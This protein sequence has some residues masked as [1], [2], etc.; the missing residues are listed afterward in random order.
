M[1]DRTL[2]RVALAISCRTAVLLIGWSTT[3]LSAGW[4]QQMDLPRVEAMPNMPQPY[5]M[6]D[7][8]SVTLAYDSLVFDLRREGTYLPLVWINPNTINYPDSPSFG[9]HTVVGTPFPQSAEAINA[10]PALVGATLSGIGKTDQFGR[11]W[12]LMAREWF[13]RRPEEN[14]YLNHPVASSG[15]DW[16]YDTMPNVFFLQLYDLYPDTPGFGEQL[17]TVADRWLIALGAMGG[18]AAPW[19]I[20]SMNYRG[21]HLSTMSPNTSGVIEPEAAGALAWILYHAYHETGHFPYRQGAEWAMEF[22]EG[23]SSNPSYELQLPYGAYA[24][25][26]MNAEIGTDFDVEKLLNW[27]FDV[28]PLRNWGAILG[29]WGGYDVHGLIGEAGSD[30]YAFAMNTFEHVGALVPLVRYDDRFSRAIGKWALNAA[31]AARLFYTAHLP[32]SLQDSDAWSHEYDPKSTIA[33]EGLRR[34]KFGRTP[35]ATGDAIEGGW[36]A[37]N[38]ALYGSSH[39]GIFGA[40]IDTTDV[41]GILRLDVRATDYFQDDGFPTYLLYNP[42]ETQRDVTFE[43]PNGTFDLYD[44]AGNRFVAHA[45]TGAAQ[46]ALPADDALQIVLLPAGEPVSY[47]FGKMYVGESIADYRTD[48]GVPNMPPRVK[49]L[50][51]APER[52]G[53]S[54]EVAAYCTAEDEDEDAG[55][56]SYEWTTSAGSISGEGAVVTWTAPDAPHEEVRLE[57]AVHDTAGLKA[58]EHITFDV[59]LQPPVI[60][61]VTANPRKVDLG[62]TTTLVCEAD[63]P[64]SDELSFSWTADAGDIEPSGSTATWSVPT[65]PGEFTATCTVRS[66]QGTSARDSIQVMVRDLSAGGTGDLVAHFRLDGDASDASAYGHDATLS[67]AVPVQDHRGNANSALRFD[68]RDDYVRVPNSDILNFRE[69]I[70]VAFWIQPDEFLDREAYP[71]SHGNWERRWKI[72][73][74]DQRLRW[75]I[76]TA[77][78]VMDLDSETLL[79]VGTFYHVVARYDGTD[80]EIYLD[81]RLDAFDG[82]AGDLLATDVDLMLGQVLPDNNAYNFA[83]VLDDVRIYEYA[84]STYDVLDLH[85]EATPSRADF[86]PASFA[87]HPPYPN[88]FDRATTIRFDLPFTAHVSLRIHDILG[89]QVALLIDDVLHA[90]RHEVVWTSARNAPGVY[91]IDLR[92][93][94]TVLRQ[95][96]VLT[97][98]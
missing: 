18:S 98:D 78:G 5:E 72:S 89:R 66:P 47:R 44:A 22:L 56:L 32:D 43:L 55:A 64:S 94:R 80:V 68:G 74:T 83:G 88:P 93:G 2:V 42:H 71:L 39:V 3:V 97:G 16:W 15:D 81:G 50:G 49:G 10:L 31:N 61:R 75:T 87:L 4:A 51:I 59:S 90:G 26:R 63:D 12:V 9:L 73:I 21:W 20:P 54:E 30:G 8:R 67:G 62:G 85:A 96:V 91:L 70:T 27:C 37:T 82:F 7:W 23:L 69:G 17:T 28:G 86:E 35:Y 34:Y 84:L 46:L 36:G 24:A 53:P 65:A 52:V 19:Q 1:K 33:H 58:S 38:L 48:E 76:K 29:N 57:C 14:V 11:N 25:A 92:S 13:N 40:I 60:S 6:R 41:P 95:A 45:V 77:S 79:Q